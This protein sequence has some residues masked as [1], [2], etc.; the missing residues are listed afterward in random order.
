MDFVRLDPTLEYRAT[1]RYR[2]Y[3]GPRRASYERKGSSLTG[4]FESY[5]FTTMAPSRGIAMMSA[6]E[7]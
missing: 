4:N 6:I 3:I 5:I 2:S 7:I 1:Q